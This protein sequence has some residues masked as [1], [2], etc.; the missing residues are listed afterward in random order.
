[1]KEKNIKIQSSLDGIKTFGKFKLGEQVKLIHQTAHHEIKFPLI[2]YEF[3]SNGQVMLK[4]K[5]KREGFAMITTMQNIKKV[6]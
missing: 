4:G 6:K 2:I 5:D 3:F 1:M